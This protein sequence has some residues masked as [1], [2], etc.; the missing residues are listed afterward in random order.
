MSLF[1]L[2]LP[3]CATMAMVIAGSSAFAESK[4]GGGSSCVVLNHFVY[5]QRT[6][7][8]N[9]A[10][11]FS[12]D[13]FRFVTGDIRSKSNVKLTTPTS[14]LTVRGTNFKLVVNDAGTIVAVN[15]GNGEIK[16]CGG[17]AETRLFGPDEAAS[18]ST[19]C[20]VTT[21]SLG[22]VP[23][24][25]GTDTEGPGEGSKGDKDPHRHTE[26]N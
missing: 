19:A 18:V 3:I 20:N 23:T 25:P 7:A 17:T 13:I 16:P 8:G 15:E 4:I 9:A 26:V 21:I 2:L 22:D 5:D 10:V 1:P 14:A 12:K 6:R 11:N 24:D